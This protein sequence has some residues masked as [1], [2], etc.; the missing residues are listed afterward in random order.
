[1][2]K[3]VLS[4][5]IPTRNRQVY[6]Q[7][8]FE[9]VKSVVS[10]NVE[11][12]IQD[13]S[14]DNSMSS[15][16]APYE[17]EQIIYHYHEGVLSFVENFSEAVALS[18][19]EYVC[20]IGDDDGV[21]PIIEQVADYCV[22]KNLDA[23][24]PALSAVYSWPCSTP[25][26]PGGEKGYLYIAPMTAKIEKLDCDSARKNLMRHS[27]QEYQTTGVPRLYHGIVSRKKLD[28]IKDRTGHYFGGLT[29]DMYMAV[30]LSYVCK[31]V[32]KA[33]FPITISGICPTSGSA[34]S[35]TGAHTGE[36]AD[37]PHF[38]GHTEYN[39]KEQ[40]PYVYSVETIWAETA[41]QAMAELGDVAQIDSVNYAYLMA[42]LQKY[43]QFNDRIK[44]H[45]EK[46]QI[47]DWLVIYNW[48][49][50]RVCHFTQRAFKALTGYRQRSKRI[51]GVP[52]IKAA[53]TII[54]NVLS[55]IKP[56]LDV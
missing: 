23:F 13:N 10:E 28:E 11:I 12:I 48:I 27:F 16:F 50:I 20:M 1:M 29:P 4:V 40:I 51:Y 36:M 3:C 37:A 30:A 14:D 31:K 8:S 21:L 45:M 19:G 6:C 24:V 56:H 49:M 34:A 2:N 15:Y 35:A 22:R 43:P 7:K 17:S 52:S 54:N 18:H 44:K 55:K 5:V 41:L 46:Y 39:W 25:Y 42:I 38:K 47:P 32:E 33:S 9:Q 26:L 53:E